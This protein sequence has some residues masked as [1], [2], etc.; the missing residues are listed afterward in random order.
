MDDVFKQTQ[1]L[2]EKVAADSV[3]AL[4][5]HVAVAPM[6]SP[7]LPSGPLTEACR[8][9]VQALT[10]KCGW[11][12]DQWGRWEVQGFFVQHD[13][14]PPARWSYRSDAME[15][16]F[17]GVLPQCFAVHVK[18]DAPGLVV[19]VYRAG[20]RVWTEVVGIG[21]ALPEVKYMGPCAVLVATCVRMMLR[22][23]VTSLQLQPFDQFYDAVRAAV[24]VT[25][26]WVAVAQAARRGM[27]SAAAMPWRVPAFVVFAV[28]PPPVWRPEVKRYMSHIWVMVASG[29]KPA[30]V[31]L[32]F[33][34]V[35]SYGLARAALAALGLLAGADVASHE[36]PGFNRRLSDTQ[37]QAWPAVW[38]PPPW[39][40]QSPGYLDPVTIS[41]E[42]HT[43]WTPTR[44]AWAHAQM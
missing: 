21:I 3:D 34:G 31:L 24:T 4:L 23:P 10:L 37:V 11:W 19:N 29:A 39:Y 36:D 6:P 43:R 2:L 33:A 20:Q 38:A 16:E 44:A 28:L 42:R 7:M 27:C 25:D 1:K 35:E 13:L 8:K 22:R 26:L 32:G 9:A 41:A 40:Y 15:A 14:V 5:Q 17:L 12:P 18:F 30:M